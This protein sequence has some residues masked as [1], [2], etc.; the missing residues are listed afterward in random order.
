MKKKPTESIIAQYACPRLR[1]IF[2]Y[3][4]IIMKTAARES[5]RT[6]TKFI[7]RKNTIL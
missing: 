5:R 4:P 1:T 2:S 7:L 3:T 6:S